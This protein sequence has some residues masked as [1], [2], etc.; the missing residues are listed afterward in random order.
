MPIR[1]I[2]VNNDEWKSSGS[3]LKY[4]SDHLQSRDSSRYIAI[5]WL[6]YISLLG[7]GKNLFLNKDIGVYFQLGLGCWDFLFA[8]V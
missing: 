1:K 3:K 6:N 4:S 2:S 7:S 8:V 5:A